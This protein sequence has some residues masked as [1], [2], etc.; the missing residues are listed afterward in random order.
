MIFASEI[1]YI[2]AAWTSIIV[3][4]IAAT[5]V[6]EN[7][8]SPTLEGPRPCTLPDAYH[9]HHEIDLPKDTPVEEIKKLLLS[10]L[11]GV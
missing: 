8:L 6:A 5:F 1:T 11:P 9:N 10:S 7:H 4:I 3:F 2:L